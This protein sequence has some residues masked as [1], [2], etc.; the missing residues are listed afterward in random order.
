M[1]EVSLWSGFTKDV[2]EKR[3]FGL[4]SECTTWKKINGNIFKE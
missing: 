4:I 1:R 2:S 3:M